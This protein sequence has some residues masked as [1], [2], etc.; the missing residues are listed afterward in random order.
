MSTP[1]AS[2]TTAAPPAGS[3]RLRRGPVV[4]TLAATGVMYGTGL[5]FLIEQAQTGSVDGTWAVLSDVGAALFG[6][7]LVPLV[8]GVAAEL[9]R[10]GSRW[11]RRARTVGLASAGLVTTGSLWLL[12]GASGLVPGSADAGL[13]AQLLGLGGFGGW[14]VHAGA[15]SLRTR[16][17]GRVAGW[18]AVAA[19]TGHLLGGVAAA[20]QQFT[21]PV[22]ALSYGAG[23]VGLVTYL[24]AL[25]RA[26]R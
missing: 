16:R 15:E 11:G 9:D 5:G 18:A 12:A 6:M 7:S 21:S 25:L 24:T 3:G 26:T 10:A 19:G 8:G 23:I 20:A 14:L 2:V 4:A 22:F 17:W 1:T 13:A